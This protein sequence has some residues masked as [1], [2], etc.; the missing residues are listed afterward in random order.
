MNVL[1][2]FCSRKFHIVYKYVI[3]FFLIFFFYRKLCYINLIYKGKMNMYCKKKSIIN[4]SIY[5]CKPLVISTISELR[6]IIK[7]NK[8]INNTTGKEL[9]DTWNNSEGF[10]YQFDNNDMIICINNTSIGVICHESVHLAHYVMN[11]IGI[12]ISLDNTEVEAYLVE[13]I[14]EAVLKVLK[15][16]IG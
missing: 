8:S 5:H 6:Y 16:S 4:I 14:L 12:S 1:T 10:V 2:L 11:Y 15:I 9:I 13:F 3:I 7:H